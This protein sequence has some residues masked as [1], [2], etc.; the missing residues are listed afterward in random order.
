MPLPAIAA[1]AVRYVG[2]KLVE[3][4]VEKA[5]DAVTSAA[6]NKTG[7]SPLDKLDVPMMPSGRLLAAAAEPAMKA[8]VSQ[9]K[10]GLK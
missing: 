5:L 6:Q 8:L 3:Q 1:V 4:G 2:A 10:F 7:E 9:A